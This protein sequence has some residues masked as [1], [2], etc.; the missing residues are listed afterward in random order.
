MDFAQIFSS[1]FANLLASENVIEFTLFVACVAFLIGIAAGFVDSTVGGGG[2]VAFPCLAL[3][4]IPPHNILATNKLQAVFGTTAAT[5]HFHKASMIDT[6]RFLPFAFIVTLISSVIGV[7][8]LRQTS[9]D[10]LGKIVPIIMLGILIYKIICFNHGTVESHFPLMK[11]SIFVAVF[12]VLLGF[13]DGFFGPGVGTFWIFALVTFLGMNSL[14]ASANAKLLNLASNI[15]ALI[16][17]IPMG[18]ICYKIAGLMGIGQVI[19]AK[20][21]VHVSM[22]KGARFINIMFIVIMS[23]M[24]IRMLAKYYF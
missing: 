16:A 13:Y 21:G 10:I 18:L 23:L 8:V 9:S 24:I 20:F 22:K 3:L 17:F 2:L 4:G 15:G 11:T 5:L 6:K 12:C 7:L 1:I 19:G 14:Q